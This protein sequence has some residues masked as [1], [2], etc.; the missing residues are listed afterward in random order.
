MRVII[1]TPVYIYSGFSVRIRCVIW[2][3]SFPITITWFRNGLRYPTRIN[4]GFIY[5][6]QPSNGDVFK[7]RADNIIGFDTAN[8]TIYVEYGKCI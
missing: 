2:N 7:C 4:A 3:G 8:T 6:T 5:L 1:G